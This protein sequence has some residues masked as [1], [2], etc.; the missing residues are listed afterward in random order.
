MSI[1]ERDP[2][3][4]HMTTGHEWNGIKELN[5]PVPRPVWFFL[6]ATFLFSL[7]YWV[8]MPA[9]PYGVSYTRGLLGLDQRD[10][11]TETV[12]TAALERSVWS[13]R[14]AAGSVD[15]IQA[16]PELMTVVREAGPAL[17]G[18]NC[19]VCHGA[20][21]QGG[22]GYPNLAQAPYL[23]GEDPETLIE[24]LRVGINSGHPE[25]R[26]SEMM[27]FGRDGLL[28]REE[29]AR[30]VDYVLALSQPELVTDVGT[31]E[32]EAGEEIFAVNCAG[33]HGEDAR[34]IADVGAP[35]LTDGFWLY[36]GDAPAIHASVHSG[37]RG[38]MPHW[39]GRLSELERKLLALYVLDLRR[40]GQ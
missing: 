35:D 18:D 34:G 12:R 28:A 11:V 23:W 14:V 31:P 5:S 19:S 1:G 13:D 8:L 33:C 39:D 24:T 17:F 36:G 22:P 10:I 38:H 27:A 2:H 26:Y 29:I 21:G 7:V 37:R 40:N 4:G 25:T 15:D 6:A 16:D 9:W 20:A 32:L 3:T 30:V